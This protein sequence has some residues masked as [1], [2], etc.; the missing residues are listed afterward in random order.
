[1]YRLLRLALI[2]FL[3]FLMLGC[4]SPEYR[5]EMQARIAE[6]NANM[7]EAKAKADQEAEERRQAELKREIGEIREICAEYGY[8]LGTSKMADC[9]KDERDKR[10][11]QRLAII[12]QNELKKDAKRAAAADALADYAEKWVADEQR[13][14]NDF[15]S[16]SGSR[17]RT[18]CRNVGSMLNCN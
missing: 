5:A 7:A 6:A 2:T 10:E 11:Q 16:R 12:H 17:L 14:I 1:M 4:T 3:S 15:N 8:K 18:T 13:R 9:I